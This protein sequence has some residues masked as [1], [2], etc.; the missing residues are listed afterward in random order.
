MITL[1]LATVL[2]M[3]ADDATESLQKAVDKIAA[4]DS[5]AFKSETDIQSPIGNAP[6]QVPTMDGK[7]QKDAGLH[8]KSDKGEIFKKG[9]RTLVKQGAA[10]WTDVA[11]FTPPAP[12]ADAPKRPR[13]GAAGSRAMLRNLKAPHEELKEVVK[14]LKDI[15]KEEKAE[16]IGDVDC[17]QYAGEMSADAMKASPLSR[18]LGQFGGGNAELKGSAKF[19]VDLQGNVAIYEVTT[20]ASVDF[21]GNQIEFS[22]VRRSEIS[23][24]GKVKVEVPEAVQKL[25]SAPVKTEEKKEDKQ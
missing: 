14:G 12:A 15:K 7:Y 4:L 17:F 10:D 11:Q 24:A 18:M 20:K 19:W 23:D 9:E 13:G 2:L 8:I 21:M 1:A 6:G 25:L 16:K 22:I 3:T 5:Y